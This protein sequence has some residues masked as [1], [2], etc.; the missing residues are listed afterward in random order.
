MF[1]TAVVEGFSQV[2]AVEVA[3]LVDLDEYWDRRA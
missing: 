2:S 1:H 3:D